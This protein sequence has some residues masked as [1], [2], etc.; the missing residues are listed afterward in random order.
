VIARDE[1][2]LLLRPAGAGLYSVSTGRAAQGA[3]QNAYYGSDD[4]D[5]VEALWRADLM[6]VG[7]AR[8]AVLGIPS[9]C[10]AGLKRGAAFGPQALREGLLAREPNLRL[11]MQEEGV[12]DVG[13]VMVVP[14]LL[15]DDMTS[16]SQKAACRQALYRGFPP[17]RVAHLPVSPLSIAE[18]ALDHLLS[19]NPELRIFVLGGDHSVA[20]PVVAALVRRRG[21]RFAIVQPDAHTDLLPERLGVKYCFATWAYHANDLLGRGGR[22]VQVGVRAS[23]FPRDHWESTLGVKQIWASELRARG[24]AATLDAIEAH[25]RTIGVED[26]YFSHDIDATDAALAPSTGAAEPAGLTGEFVHA[27]IRRLGERFTLV[28]ADMVEVAPPIGSPE[29]SRRTVELATS[30]VWTSIEGLLKKART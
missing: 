15:H 25:L 6:G 22:L 27:L 21:P 2:P 26:V 18:R 3:F 9:D 24:D 29:E 28:G 10:G 12:I 17:E 19:L 20:W 14:H 11:W 23:R 5:T 8:V 13:D 30:Y 16:E 4:A 7:T 1:L